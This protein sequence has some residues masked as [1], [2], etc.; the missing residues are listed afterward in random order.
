MLTVVDLFSSFAFAVPTKDQ[1]AEIAAQ[2]IW[3]EIVRRYGCP[4]LL[5]DQGPAFESQV[6]RE[7]CEKYGCTMF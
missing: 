7:L 6:L 2:V 5:S 1:M 3:E 4:E